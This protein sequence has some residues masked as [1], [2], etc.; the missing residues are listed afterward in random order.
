MAFLFNFIL[1]FRVLTINIQGLNETKLDLISDYVNRFNIDVCFVQETQVSREQSIS[2]LSARWD[3]RSLWS[4]ALGRQGGVAV[5]FSRH[6]LGDICS[7]KKDNEGRIESVLVSFGNLNCN[8]VNVY[9]PTNRSE[10]S[11]FFLSV[12]QY[13]FPCSQIIFGG[14]LNCYD[15]ALG[16][17]VSLSSDL[18]SFKSCFKFVDAWRSKHPR[19]SQFSWF[20]S[21]LTIGSRLD[22]FLITHDFLNSLTSCKISPCAFSDHEFVTLDIDLSHVFDFGPGVWKFNN[23]LLDDHIYCA[24]IADLIDQHLSFKHVF[25]S[26]KDFWESLKEVFRNSTINYSRTKRKELSRDR[27]RITNRL[28]KLKF[29]LVNGDDSVKS[30]ILELESELSAIFRQ[31]LDGIKIRSRAKW[32]EEGEIPSRFFFKLGRE[33]FDR[34]VVYSMYNLNGVAVSDWAGLIKA[35]EDF[36]ANLFSRDEIDL[37]VQQELF[38][39]LSLRL[40]D[41]D[42]DKCEGLLTLSELTVALGNMSKNKAPGP[43]GFSVE[44]YSKF[45]NLLGPILLE[46]INLCYA[47]FD[48][49]ESMK[50]SNTR[51]VFKKGDRQ[52]VKNWRPISLLNVDYKICSKALST[53]LS[54]VLDKIVSPNQTCSVPGRSIS[55]NLVMIRDMLDYIDRTNEPGILI[56]LDQEK[57]FDRVDRSF[58]MNLLQHFGFGPSFCRW[59]ATLYR[60]ANM[61]IMI[62][63]WLSRK[64]DLQ[65][66]VRQGDSL[67]PM[68]YIL[69]VEVLAAKI[70]STPAIEGFLL[71]GARGKCFKVGQYADDIT[72]FLKNLNSLRVLLNTISVYERGSGAKLNRSKSEAMWVGSWRDCFDQPFGLTWV[73]KMKI[74]GVFFGVIDVPRDN[75]EPKLSKLDKMLTLWKSRSLSMVGKSLIINVLGISKLLYLARVLITPR[76]VID[77]YNSLIWNFLWGSKIEPVARKTLHCPIDKGGLGIVDFE[78][79]GRAL[80]LALCLSVLDDRTPN[81]FY[82]ARYFCGGRL[83]RFGSR[84]ASLRDIS[85]PNATSPT[86]FYTGSISTLEKLARLPTSFVFLS[87][88]VYRELLKELSSPPILPRFWSP[89]LRPPLDMEEHW[90]LVRDSRTENFKSD[91][92]WLITLKA[93]KVRESLR[94]WG[95]IPSDRCASCPRRETIDHCFL[96]CSRVKLVWAFF[97]PL[98]SALLTPPVPFVPNCVSVF[99]FRFPSCVSRDRAIIIYLI[100]SIL[101]SIWKFRNKATFHN[102]KESDRAIIRYIIQDVTN[103]IKLDHFRLPAVKFSSLWVHPNFCLVVGNDRLTFPFINR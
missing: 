101:Y 65:R 36:Y 71:P 22:S 33:R 16:G 98:L 37:S 6:F 40:S 85:S 14:D 42:R 50:T 4:P 17:N 32:L 49:C 38:T 93:V 77:R 46:V 62:N 80:R 25:V 3:G 47:D 35:H 45:W 13:F 95:Y 10:W 66:G 52:S 96:N 44:F 21:D 53:R 88:N 76:W 1:I 70:R 73:K 72:G 12:H 91:L 23:S 34:N 63:G 89:L 26:M 102:G 2:S 81:C 94:N 7:W 56:S 11:T 84:W 30:E 86:L 18:S 27:V 92:S 28:V 75:W 60:G 82:L 90:A 99:V 24:L 79:K 8:L 83:A 78:V 64:I 87:K 54:L 51:P 59:I 29:R 100:K 41:E 69:C 61:Q 5:L 20:S 15:S 39:N 58:L 68:Q 19:V 9:A 48:L 55:S 67:S 43:D 74:L 97:V 31:E 57:A 103:R